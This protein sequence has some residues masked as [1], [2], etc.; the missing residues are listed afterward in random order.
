VASFSQQMET[1]NQII[2]LVLAREGGIKV[3][4]ALPL[5]KGLVVADLTTKIIPQILP[6]IGRTLSHLRPRRPTSS[7]G[8]TAQSS[9]GRD[10][11]ASITLHRNYTDNDAPNE[12]FDALIWRMC[13][14]P[15]TRFL[16]L[17][18]NNVYVISN[19]QI[20]HIDET[21]S[22]KQLSIQFDEANNVQSASVEVFSYTLDL[23][24]LKDLLAQFTHLYRQHLNNQLGQQLYYFDNIPSSLPKTLEGQVNYDTAQRHLTF[25]MSKM[26]TNKSLDNVYG[27]AMQKVRKRVHF[28]LHNKQW[29]AK[30]GTPWTLGILMSGAPGTGKSSL[31]KAISKDARRHIFN[32][33]LSESTTV[34][35][36]NNLFYNERISVLQ[37]GQNRSYNIPIDQ[38]IIVME[39]VDCLTSIVLSRGG[40]PLQPTPER[41]ENAEAIVDVTDVIPSPPSPDPGEQPIKPGTIPTM[42]EIDRLLKTVDEKAAPFSETIESFK[43][44][45]TLVHMITDDF[46]ANSAEAKQKFFNQ[47]SYIVLDPSQEEDFETNRKILADYGIYVKPKA[48]AKPSGGFW[49]TIEGFKERNLFVHL[50]TDAFDA[51]PWKEKLEFFVKFGGMVLN[52]KDTEYSQ[53]VRIL[54]DNG[55]RVVDKSPE[56]IDFI[57]VQE[58]SDRLAA[59]NERMQLL[60]A[61]WKADAAKA[62]PLDYQF[63]HKVKHLDLDAEGIKKYNN[64]VFL[65]NNPIEA[66]KVMQQFMPS[67]PTAGDF[68]SI[69]GFSSFDSSNHTSIASSHKPILTPVPTMAPR[70]QAF[71]STPIASIATQQSKKSTSVLK[72]A[73]PAQMPQTPHFAESLAPPSAP[74]NEHPE[75]LT[76]SHLLNVLDGILETPGR[77]FIMT[78]NYPERLDSALVRPGRIDLKVHFT[79]SSR[80][81]ILQMIHKLTDH[82]KCT[83]QDL[84]DIPDMKYT[85]AEVIQ[86][87]FENI[88]SLPDILTALTL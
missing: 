5:L 52:P 25:T 13:Q 22:L 56:E 51:R 47:H 1:A 78:S 20:I 10:K 24:Q 12:T 80:Q 38:R 71:A 44:R 42:A 84:R 35:Q 43:A 65:V 60:S 45:H 72:Q 29:Y 66:E 19:T 33:K 83:L 31:L 23:L 49:D 48:D 36:I 62:N 8:P 50:H 58:M 59:K 85:P 73:M 53:K 11:T 26:E 37:D 18:A 9:R 76:L 34:S 87:I 74:A 68:S 32:I 55:I 39:D 14:L 41:H 64:S 40:T 17:T 6:A 77:I 86:K 15:Q 70:P 61:K 88:E 21:L 63:E 3:K 79:N 46:E 27:T 81:D 30:T 28:F 54:W 69:D 2:P 7:N 75:R 4:D 82:Q 67:D 16:K 57:A